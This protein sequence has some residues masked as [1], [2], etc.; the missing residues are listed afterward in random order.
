MK[1]LIISGLICASLFSCAPK[2]EEGTPAQQSLTQYVDPFIGT[3]YHGHTFPGAALPSGMIQLSPDNG[4]SGW[5]WCS[6]YHYSDSLIAGFSHLHLSGT[7]IGDLADISVMPTN[8]E[9]AEKHFE[10]GKSF[11]NFYRS[12][13]N[14]DNEEAT[15]GYYQVLL[16]DDNINVELSVTDRVGFHRYT[17]N[18]SKNK[19]IIFDLG[20]HINW[21]KP[22]ETY[23][24]KVADDMVVGYRFSKGWAPLQ[25]VF[26]VAKFSQ[27][28]S[29]FQTFFA[30]EGKGQF[31]KGVLTFDDKAKNEILMK[32][33]ISSASIEG[34][35]KNLK[36]DKNQWNFEQVVELADATW[37]KE[38][39]RITV[40]TDNEDNKTVFYTSLYHSLLAPYLFS[41]V[42]GGYKGYDNNTHFTK[43]YKKYTVLSLWDTFRA[44]KPLF[45]IIK[46]E[47]TNNIVKSM[48]DQYQE[49]GLLPV[50]ELVGNENNC[51]IGYHAV[52]V[53]ADAIL[54]G[55]GDFD[56]NLAYKAMIASSMSDV[57]GLDLYRKYKY[58]PSDKVNESASKTL[59]Y[60][61]DDWCI[62][63]VAK[64]LG[65]TADYE[66]YMERSKYYKNLFDKEIGF[67]RGKKADGKWAT[68]FD[69]KF[70]KHR[71]DYFT[72]G[73]S[74]Q[75]TWFAPHDIDG[76]TELMGGKE[77]FLK[78]LDQLFNESSE[79]KGD[80]ASSD[81]TGLIGQ[82]A[83]GNE[84]SHHTSYM[85][86]LAGAPWLTQKYVNEILTTMYTPEPDGLCGNE[87][88]GQMSAWY[89]FSSMGFYPANAASGVYQIGS[90]MFDKAT[91]NLPNGKTFTVEAPNVSD[92]NIYVQSATLNGKPLNGTSITHKQLSEGGK[93]V[94]TMGSQ[95]K[96]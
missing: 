93:L 81:I 44:L 35:M 61:Y 57:D 56:V 36:A 22:S 75:W 1:Q 21:D 4:T 37:E 71:K 85:F 18:N 66:K 89:V 84:P 76:L 30:K 25:K 88:C 7:G 20:F 83:H 73:N 15:P 79:I 33:A 94:L 6:G 42:D 68:P 31:T 13:F 8:K 17:F 43:G 62:A 64:K 59:A 95:P 26:F 14:H 29:Q 39:S 52:P 23:I 92:K 91:I 58:I 77:P 11:S 67:V 48:L 28:F 10:E 32:V 34:A 70:S 27:P 54:K 12:K 53:V 16:D 41:D 90:P 78:K 49:T 45:T 86:N 24:K 19:S 5:D 9:I 74:W 87:D 60:S 96:K 2:T 47:L 63:Q 38:L 40:E 80:H 3:A 55:I 69:P 65:K 51:M 50:W 72:E 82:Y 46:P